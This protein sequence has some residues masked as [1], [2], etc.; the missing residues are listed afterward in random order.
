MLS[1][2]AVGDFGLGADLDDQS[3]RANI[4][5]ASSPNNNYRHNHI[6]VQEMAW[7]QSF[8]DGHFVAMAGLINQTNYLDINRYAN[9][10]HGQFLNSALVNSQVLPAPSNN[11]GLN[12]QWQPVDGFYAM[13]GLGP[14]NQQLGQNPAHDVSNENFSY[15]GELGLVVSDLWGLGQGTY[16]LQPFTA[17]FD[18]KSGNGIA[19]N[20]EQQ[21]GA[22]SP[23]GAFARVGV[24]DHVTGSI[25]GGV[26][27][28]ASAGLAM[29]A[30]FGQRGPF[31]YHNNDF[32]GIGFVWSEVVDDPTFEHRNEYGVE[33]T[34][35]IQ[36]T[37][38]ATIQPDLQFVWDPVSNPDSGPAIVAQIQLNIAW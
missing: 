27:A 31:S 3:P 30:P 24:G 13:L 28:Q 21:L 17:T 15:V 5:A 22:G 1:A 10:A 35:A 16:R 8:F 38:S 25:P 18:G 4:G 20:L 6:G 7:A 29:L 32:A 23:L 11:L 33:L 12:F 36:L 37:P 9:S 34:M 26:Q 19:L 14:N 2:K